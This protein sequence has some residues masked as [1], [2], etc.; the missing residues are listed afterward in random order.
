MIA[1]IFPALAAIWTTPA[2][3]AQPGNA[4]AHA[5]FERIDAC[6]DGIDAADDFMARHDREF[7]IWQF[8][9]DDVKVGAAN[10]ASGDPNPHLAVAGQRIGPLHELERFA[11]PFQHHRLHRGHPRD[12]LPIAT[13]SELNPATDFLAGRSPL[14]RTG[15]AG[16]SRKEAIVK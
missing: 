11:Q 4:D 7:G 1:Q 10:A 12:E 14:L 3:P 16:Q 8:A 15:R 13:L 6:T 5:G 2:S 9:V